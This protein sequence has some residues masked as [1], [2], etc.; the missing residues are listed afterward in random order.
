MKKKL[1][2]ALLVII[3]TSLMGSSF[4]VAKIG[5]EY[6][7]PLLLVGMRFTMAGMI[8]GTF[9]LLLKKKHP[10]K[11]S[12]WLRIAIVGAVQTAGV[13]GAIFLSLRTITAGESAILTFTNPLLVVIF[14][15]LLLRIR[16]RIVQWGGVLIGFFGVFI[17]MGSHVDLE[18]GTFLAFASAVSWAIGTLL[19]K[20]WGLL[21]DIWVL[22]AYQM[23]FGGLILLAGSALLEDVRLV[24][25]PTSVS[26]L[27]WLSIPAS[28]I[29]F[30]IWFSLLQNGNPGKVS[31]FLFLAPLFGVLSGWLILDEKIGWSLVGGGALIFSGIFLVNWP[32]KSPKQEPALR[33]LR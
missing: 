7:S 25:N 27:L 6:F 21:F 14:G 23:L 17:T 33:I 15:T 28:I 10:K 31:A 12:D 16:Y 22:T 18:V 30:A 19:I 5:L 20:K 8:M 1:I 13:M 24:L 11:A 2:F 4:A 29:Q 32:E 3:T 26:I 9:V